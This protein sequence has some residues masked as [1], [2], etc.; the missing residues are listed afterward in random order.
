M[1]ACYSVRIPAGYV[2]D[3]C[4]GDDAPSLIV[5]KRRKAWS[6]ARWSREEADAMCCLLRLLGF[7]D[8]FIESC[9]PASSYADDA[10]EV[11]PYSNQRRP[12]N[13][14]FFGQPAYAM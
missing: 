10:Q 11:Y 4:L 13:R 14:Q 12:K 6:K 7:S 5:V 9:F 1:S 3:V 2:D 8:A